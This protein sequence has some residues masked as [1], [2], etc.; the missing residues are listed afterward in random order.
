MSLVKTTPGRPV[1]FFFSCAGADTEE[2]AGAKSEIFIL[3]RVPYPY[4]SE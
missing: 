2:T 1:G 4:R 3:P